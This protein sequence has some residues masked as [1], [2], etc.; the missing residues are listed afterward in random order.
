[1]SKH[2]IGN[3]VNKFI[4]M[5]LKL[6]ERVLLEILKAGNKSELHSIYGVTQCAIFNLVNIIKSLYN[7]LN[8][9]MCG[10]IVIQLIIM[11]SLMEDCVVVKMRVHK[12]IFRNGDLLLYNIG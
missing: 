6:L 9:H 1:M 7:I 12:R 3:K 5:L 2:F 11:Y 10:Y 4:I 8:P